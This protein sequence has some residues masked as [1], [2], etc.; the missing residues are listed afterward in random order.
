DDR[1]EVFGFLLGELVGHEPFLLAG[2]LADRDRVGRP[3]LHLRAQAE[4]LVLGEVLLPVLEQQVVLLEIVAAPGLDRVGGLVRQGDLLDLHRVPRAS[5]SNLSSSAWS[6]EGAS[7]IADRNPETSASL[8]S[9]SVRTVTAPSDRKWS[10]RAAN[11]C[12]PRSRP[13]KSGSIPK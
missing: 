10:T 5:P 8:R 3:D 12:F 4:A 9:T 1:E 7:P 2:V 11:I 6:G 13:R